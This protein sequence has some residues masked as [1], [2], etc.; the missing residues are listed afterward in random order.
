ML[1]Q[2]LWKLRFVIDIPYFFEFKGICVKWGVDW[3][4]L[5]YELMKPDVW[6]D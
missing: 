6:Y 3:R 1:T 5:H 2:E 4:K